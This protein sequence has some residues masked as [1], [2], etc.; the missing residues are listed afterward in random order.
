MDWLD[1]GDDEGDASDLG[2]KGG[3]EGEEE[4]EGEGGASDDGASDEGEGAPRTGHKGRPKGASS[5][6][7]LP[8]KAADLRNPAF[9]GQLAHFAT[10]ELALQALGALG[11]YGKPIEAVS[12]KKFT[13]GA[14]DRNGVKAHL[15]SYK[16]HCTDRPQTED[17]NRGAGCPHQFK[18]Q[19]VIKTNHR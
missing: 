2:I 18:V 8:A 16:V 9:P 5:I 12:K 3:G 4:G 17:G 11:N 7:W 1:E 15:H 14:G 19:E 13:F 10:A 6:L